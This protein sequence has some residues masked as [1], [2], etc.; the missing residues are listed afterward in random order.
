ME[1]EI[2]NV[3]YQVKSNALTKF[4]YKKLF[5]VG[6]FKDISVLNSINTKSEKIRKELK[7]TDLT[8]EEIEIEVNNQLMGESDAIIDVALKMAYVLIYTA[9]NQFMSFEQWLGTIDKVDLKETW[10]SEVITTISN[11]FC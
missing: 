9:N 10:V 11:T 2:N 8:D 5:G 6:I 4:H 1:I 7:G 3:K